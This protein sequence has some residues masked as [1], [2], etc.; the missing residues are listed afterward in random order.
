MG[1]FHKL[2]GGFSHGF[3]YY[4]E[5]FF[6]LPQRGILWH[7]VLSSFRKLE[8]DRRGSAYRRGTGFRFDMPFAM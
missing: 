4:I 3:A 1:P 7:K 5:S 8:K 2:D 6:A